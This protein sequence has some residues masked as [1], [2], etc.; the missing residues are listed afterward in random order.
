MVGNIVPRQTAEPIF[1]EWLQEMDD[2]RLE[3]EAL[4]W[5]WLCET[6]K[7]GPWEED[8]WRRECVKDECQR[9]EKPDPPKSRTKNSHSARQGFQVMRDLLTDR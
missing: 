8:K 2:R 6:T 9:R 7:N 3:S 4:T 1:R 5:I